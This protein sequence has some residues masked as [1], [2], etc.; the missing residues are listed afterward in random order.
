ML[1]TPPVIQPQATLLALAGFGLLLGMRHA[2]EPDH[3]AAVSTLLD[4]GR[5]RGSAAAY[6]GAFWGFGHTLAILGLGGTLLALRVEL[7]LRAQGLLELAVAAMLVWL[8]GRGLW[9]AHRLRHRSGAMHA[10]PGG[11]LHSHGGGGAEHVHVGPFALGVRPL[12]VGLV[13]GLAGTGALTSLVMATLPTVGSAV[14]YLASFGLGSLLGMAGVTYAASA[15]L[16]SLGATGSRAA[17]MSATGFGSLA[18]GMYWGAQQLA[19]LR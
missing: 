2:L 9:R 5:R 19:V 13:H 12:L 17:L 11:R 18:Y 14:G 1:E 7:P 16:A 3:L 4:G 6:L 15:S 8:G 10:H